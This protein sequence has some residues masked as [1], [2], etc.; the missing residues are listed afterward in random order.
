[1]MTTVV[2]MTSTTMTDRRRFRPGFRARVLGTL[3]VLLVAALAIGLI[4]QRAVLERRLDRDVAAELDQERR[5]IISLAAGRNPETGQEF[6]GNVRAIFDTFLERNV[7]SEGE[8]YLTFVGA[9]PYKATRA[10][11]GVRLDLEPE[12][13]SRWTSL[14]QGERGR[15]D[16]RAGEVEYL[17]V[18][19]QRQGR[20]LGV[21]VVANFLRTDREELESGIRVEALVS[22]I[23]LLI[24]IGVAWIVAGRLLRPVRDLTDQARSISE[25]DL[26]GRIPVEGDDEIA[27]L[28][29]TFNEM[30]DR[31][32]SAFSVQRA[33][34]DDAGHELRTPI[35]I[36]RGHL[37]VMGDDPQD[38]EETLALV[39]DELDRMARIV[40]DLLILAKA[41]QPDFVRL[42]PVELNDFTTGLLMKARALGT[43]DWQFDGCGTGTVLADPQRL[44]QAVLNLAR[45]AVEHT[46][47]GAEIGIGSYRRNGELRLWV[48]D[49]GTGI[50][51]YERDRIF[52]RFARAESRPRTSD[53]AGLGLSIVRA[54]AIGHHGRVELDNRPGAGV[55]FTLVLPDGG[56]HPDDDLATSVESPDITLERTTR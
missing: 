1:M 8:V 15:L 23:V 43:R 56:P 32:E 40:D 4:V 18:P 38:R 55:T 49:T 31:L 48:R 37:E 26:S 12:L 6:G 36:V 13:V 11:E 20:N 44:S 42:E 22:G 46:T 29:R 39:T 7:A 28:A 3:A 14:T 25:T 10:P 5:E 41:E 30:L 33:F 35:T 24:A 9:S 47:E 17:A 2:T 45:N 52:E 27:E 50:D 51:P 34:V 16:T 54:V 19:L 21:F 53:G